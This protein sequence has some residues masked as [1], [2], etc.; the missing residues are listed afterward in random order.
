[1]DAAHLHGARRSR[2]PAHSSK[3]ASTRWARAPGLVPARR[4]RGEADLRAQR[5]RALHDA[6]ARARPDV[7]GD[8]RAGRRGRPRRPRARA[9][10]TR[11]R[12]S[13]AAARRSSNGALV[14]NYDYHP[15]RIEAGR[16]R[17][18]RAHAARARDERLPVGP[19]GRHQRRRAR[20]R[21][22]VRRPRGARR[23]LRDHARRALPA[24]DLRRRSRQAVATLARLPIHAPYNLTLVR[25]ATARRGRSAS[26]PTGP[27]A[28]VRPAVATNHQEHVDWLEH[29]AATRSV[30]RHA[31]L[32]AARA[33][34]RSSR[35]RCTRPSTGAAS[36]RSTPPPTA[37]LARAVDLPLARMSAGTSRSPPLRPARGPSD[38]G[39][40]QTA[41]SALVL[42]DLVAQ[43]DL[44]LTLLSG[45]AGALDREIAG[46]HS[47]DVEAPTRFLERH[48]VMLTAGMRLKGSVAAQR[49]LVAELDEGGMSALGIGVGL[50]FKRVPPALLEEARER[51]FPVLAVP[52]E[53]RVPGHRRLHQPLAAVERPAHLPAADGDPAPPGRRAA[54][55]APA[56]GDGGAAGADAGR[57]RAAARCRRPPREPRGAGAGCGAGRGAVAEREFEEDGWHVVAVPIGAPAGSRSPAAGAC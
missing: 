19:A 14:R 27:R 13:P 39:S 45:G 24:R 34:T 38:S 31:A 21:A 30:E 48:W 11:R 37:P 15:D 36:A 49:A 50:V 22:R 3:R 8:D 2:S 55:A 9:S 56:R 5:A 29:A 35:R 10:T 12:C 6:H 54:R 25:R 18:A 23:R 4:R 47:I 40:V 43:E 46:A 52:L 16:L 26:A 57:R 7:G 1:M 28:R 17:A 33:R 41:T 32:G 44:G 42:G 20:G 53:T 51:S